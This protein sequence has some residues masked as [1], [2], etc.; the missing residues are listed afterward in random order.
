MAKTQIAKNA[1]VN[2]DEEIYLVNYDKVTVCKNKTDG[3]YA[4]RSDITDSDIDANWDVDMDASQKKF[5]TFKDNFVK[6]MT[7]KNLALAKTDSYIGRTR[8][9]IME[10][11][12]HCIAVE[13]NGWSFAIEIINKDANNVDATAMATVAKT[14]RD[15]LLDEFDTVC[16][17]TGTFSVDT[18]TKT[19][20]D[21]DEEMHARLASASR[22]A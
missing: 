19:A 8:H 4:V 20:V 22:K 13:D 10:S 12:L 16:I 17:R 7:G 6:T 2:F 15:T 14:V 9:V 3:T 21:A 5:D 11:P 1:D 18:I